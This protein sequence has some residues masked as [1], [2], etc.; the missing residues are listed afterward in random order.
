MNQLKQHLWGASGQA[1]PYA[2]AAV[3]HERSRICVHP[4]TVCTLLMKISNEI[5]IDSPKRACFLSKI[6]YDYVL[7]FELVF[8]LRSI[9]A[10]Q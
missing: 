1:D 3:Q 7:L 8:L 2:A 9:Y 5:S 10:A 6:S 4:Q